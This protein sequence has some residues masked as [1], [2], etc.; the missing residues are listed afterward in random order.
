M[1]N[2]EHPNLQELKRRLGQTRYQEWLYLQ[3]NY[4]SITGDIDS[5]EELAREILEES[6]EQLEKDKHK[7]PDNIKS[8]IKGTWSD[9]G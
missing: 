4:P 6:E 1:N 7:V 5:L 3:T 2:E 8:E 9:N